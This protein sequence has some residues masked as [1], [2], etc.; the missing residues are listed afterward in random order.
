MIWG[1]ARA[2]SGSFPRTAPGPTP[3]SEAGV[4]YKNCLGSFVDAHTVECT[5]KKGKRTRVTARRV[6]I[7]VG[8]RPKALDCPGG[9]VRLVRHRERRGGQQGGAS[10]TAQ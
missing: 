7:A 3:R 5:D 8:G 4:E 9:E 6:V 2:P 1:A 10:H